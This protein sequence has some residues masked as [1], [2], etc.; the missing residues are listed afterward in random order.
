[1]SHPWAGVLRDR[2]NEIAARHE[3]VSAVNE[4]RAMAERMAS[5]SAGPALTFDVWWEKGPARFLR[6]DEYG[7]NTVR[8][9]ASDAFAAGRLARRASNTTRPT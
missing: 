6:E 8:R 1:M 5:E 9:F 2:A 3:A 7:I 4:L